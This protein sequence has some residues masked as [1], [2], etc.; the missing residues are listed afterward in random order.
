M[1][2]YDKRAWRRG[3]AAF[4]RFTPCVILLVSLAACSAS[5]PD[6]AS[7]A[8][9]DAWLAFHGGTVPDA[10]IITLIER[11]GDTHYVTATSRAKARSD[12]L[13]LAGRAYAL[14]LTGNRWIEASEKVLETAE[15][16]LARGWVVPQAVEDAKSELYRVKSQVRSEMETSTVSSIESCDFDAA[17]ASLGI[18]PVGDPDCVYQSETMGDLCKK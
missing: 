13:E 18:E 4:A 5:E 7:N 14:A 9:A 11:Y 8:G 16:G 2:A 12:A 10:C 3:T 1:L 6:F 15:E 17:H